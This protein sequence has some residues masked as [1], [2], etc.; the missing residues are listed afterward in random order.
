[1]SPFS[2]HDDLI[3][4][5]SGAQGK[6]YSEIHKALDLSGTRN[7]IASEYKTLLDPLYKTSSVLKVANGV[8]VDSGLKINNAY[9]SLLTTNYHTNVKSLKFADSQA[10][11]DV[12]NND[13]SSATNGKIQDIMPASSLSSDTRLVLVNS[14]YFLS[15]W[16]NKFD[17]YQTTNRIF[18]TD[19]SATVQLST[20]QQ[21]VKKNIEP[22]SINFIITHIFRII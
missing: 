18:Y 3:M 20:M 14:V 22:V 15:T 11:A 16:L 9:R 21:M 6:T 10:S 12:I 4:A 8:Y 13:M 1:M 5:G 19:L 2:I 17:K 7:Q